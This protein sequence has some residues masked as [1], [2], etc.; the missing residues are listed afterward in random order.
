VFGP[1]VTRPVRQRVAAAVGQGFSDHRSGRDLD[2]VLLVTSTGGVATVT[3]F[4][5]VTA[6]SAYVDGEPE[7][8]LPAM[9]VALSGGCYQLWCNPDNA[10]VDRARSWLQGALR[11]VEVELMREV[12]RRLAAVRLSL[13]AV[14]AEAVEHGV[15]LA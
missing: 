10:D 7:L 4:A 8:L 5:A 11:E 14:L 1:G 9:G 15:L 12:S 3:G 13:S 6:L 2:R